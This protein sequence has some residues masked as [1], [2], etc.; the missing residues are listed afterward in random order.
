MSLYSLLWQAFK[1]S[2]KFASVL[3]SYENE[4]NVKKILFSY[5]DRPQANPLRSSHWK[6]RLSFDAEFLFFFFWNRRFISN[7]VSSVRRRCPYT[8]TAGNKMKN[9]VST[10][11]MVQKQNSFVDKE[12]KTCKQTREQVKRQQKIL[13]EGMADTNR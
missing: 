8:R 12:K 3:S 9:F 2:D 4:W 10:M 7:K 5:E 13:K 11:T 6:V 1:S